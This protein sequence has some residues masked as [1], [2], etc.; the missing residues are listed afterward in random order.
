MNSPRCLLGLL[1]LLTCSLCTAQ[2]GTTT[3]QPSPEMETGRR[4]EDLITI[5]GNDSFAKTFIFTTNHW[6][7]SADH[8][9]TSSITLLTIAR[10][11]NG[12][13]VF[14]PLAVTNGSQHSTKSLIGDYVDIEAVRKL[15]PAMTLFEFHNTSDYKLL[16]AAKSSSVAFPKESQEEYEALLSILGTIRGSFIAMGMPAVDPENTNQYCDAFRGTVH[17]E[18]NSS[19]RFIFLDRIHFLHFCTEKF[20]PWWYD[21]RY[22]IAPRHEYYD[23]AE[24]FMQ[25]KKGM[26][27]I[28]I[29]DAMEA[30]IS[31]ERAEFERYA[32]QIVDALRKNEALSRPLYLIY[33]RGGVN[34]EKVVALLR[35]E[36]AHVHSCMDVH[37]CLTKV[38]AEKNKVFDGEMGLKMMEWAMAS[39][40]ELYIGNIHSPYSR[41]I[42][43]HRKMHGMSYSV[44]TGFGELRKVWKWKLK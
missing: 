3:P 18:R 22:R 12:T 42:C 20:M 33:N 29:N 11:F 2:N 25:G 14:P 37:A 1:F 28:H 24:K 32:R 7:E 9:L 34:V 15:Q 8:Q 40:A 6:W 44:L 41:N 16:K 31:R 19:T 39:R 21:V 10:L 27:V 30:H 23:M 38:P 43:L 35:E 26:T 13:A 5:H 4:Y 36:L 17:T